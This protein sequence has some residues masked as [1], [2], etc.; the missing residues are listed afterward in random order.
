MTVVAL[1]TSVILAGCAGK[2][3]RTMEDF[4]GSKIQANLVETSKGLTQYLE[5]RG[6]G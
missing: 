6:G 4:L 2:V 5:R 3:G 1:L